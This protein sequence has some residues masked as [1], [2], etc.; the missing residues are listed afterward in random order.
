M[1]LKH[2]GSFSGNLRTLTFVLLVSFS[3]ASEADCSCACDCR[4]VI[5]CLLA[6]IS[7]SFPVHGLWTA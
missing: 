5:R 1:T 4:G 6:A 7:H 3:T 2:H